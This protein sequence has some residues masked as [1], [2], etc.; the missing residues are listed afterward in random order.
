MFW[1]QNNPRNRHIDHG[2]G[3]LPVMV[4]SFFRHGFRLHCA[5]GKVGFLTPHNLVSTTKRSEHLSC[6]WNSTLILKLSAPVQDW[7]RISVVLCYSQLTEHHLAL[8]GLRFVI[9]WVT[10]TAL[11]SAMCQGTIPQAATSC[12][13]C[14][15]AVVFGAVMW[16]KGLGVTAL[17]LRCLQ[18]AAGIPVTWGVCELYLLNV[19]PRYV[20]PKC[21]LFSRFT[22]KGADLLFGQWCLVRK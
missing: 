9:R 18:C 16:G 15:H 3:Q 17:Y 6:N 11:C 20:P 8:E 14:S 5:L 10:A 2:S 13:L 1:K 19:S 7:A 22:R 21:Q 12:S 4:Q